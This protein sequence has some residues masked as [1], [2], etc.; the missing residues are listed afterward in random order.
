VQATLSG[1]TF[2]N[3]GLSYPALACGSTYNCST[4]VVNCEVVNVAILGYHIGDCKG[5]IFAV[6][7]TKGQSLRQLPWRVPTNYEGTWTLGDCCM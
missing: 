3:F 7:G 6:P 4:P 5:E 2:Q 1:I